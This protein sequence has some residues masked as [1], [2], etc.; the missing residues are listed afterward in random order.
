MTTTADTALALAERYETLRVPC[1]NAEKPYHQHSGPRAN[2][3]ILD[4]P[5]CHGSGWQPLT[6]P[7]ALAA[8]LEIDC[9]ALGG[10]NLY[11]VRTDGWYC[12]L[13]GGYVGRGPTPEAALAEAL[14]KASA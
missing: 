8:M 2:A 9:V 1:P 10:T 5:V 6:G 11:R 13:E 7:A 4:C 12:A 3:N 14:L